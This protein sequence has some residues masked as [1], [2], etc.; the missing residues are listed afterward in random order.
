MQIKTH[1]VM[2]KMKPFLEMK[3][4][5]NLDQKRLKLKAL[6]LSPILKKEQPASEF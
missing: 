4:C 3:R 5:D 6:M 1:R 2:D